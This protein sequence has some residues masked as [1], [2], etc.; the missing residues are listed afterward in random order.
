MYEIDE[1][2]IV[3]FSKRYMATIVLWS[4]KQGGT[5]LGKLTI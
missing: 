4:V 2:Q 1:L 3:L 5:F